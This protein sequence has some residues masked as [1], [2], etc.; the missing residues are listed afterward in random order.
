MSGKPVGDLTFYLDI[1]VRE[2]LL[3]SDWSHE[4]DAV[5]RF[6]TAIENAS[7]YD[8]LNTHIDANPSINYDIANYIISIMHNDCN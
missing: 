5:N 3:P 2:N 1:N 8:K 7:I 6:K 4:R